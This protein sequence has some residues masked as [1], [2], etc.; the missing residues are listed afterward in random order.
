MQIR[1]MTLADIPQVAVLEA[2]N[3]TMPWSEKGFADA[4]KQ[5]EHIFLV[6]EL[7][8]KTL[9]A[10]CGLYASGDEGEITNVAVSDQVRRQG[11]GQA[12]VA[13]VLRQA[14]YQGMRQIFLEVR[15]TNTGARNLYEKLGFVNC[16]I[17][18]NFYQKPCEDAVLMRKDLDETG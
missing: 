9:A 7:E 17:R 3:F 5:P 14:E 4:L 2:Q 13:E 16:G 18:K 6:A 11:I 15:K 8:D 12:V 1:R 10:Y